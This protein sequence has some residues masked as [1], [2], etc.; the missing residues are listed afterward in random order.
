MTTFALAVTLAASAI[1]CNSARAADNVVAPPIL[2]N[3]N[4]AWSWFEDERAVVD[5]TGGKLLVS[6]VGDSAGSGGTARNG[7][8]D[9]VSYNL[10]TGVTQSFLLHDNLQDDDHNSAA[11]FVRPDGKYLAM[12]ARHGSDNFSRWRISTNPHDATAW[13]PEQTFN[14][15]AGTTYSNLHYLPADN[16]GAGRTYNFTRTNNYDP[17]VLVSD[18]QGAS[19]SYGGKLLTEGGGGDRPYVRYFDDG[20]RI[21]LITTER[22]PR[23]Y[24]NSVYYG[25][26][27][28]AKLYGAG[29]AVLDANLLDGAAVTPASLTPVMQTGTVVDGD[30]MR[31][32]WTVDAAVDGAGD[33]VVVFQARAN[34]SDLDHRFF[35][36]RWTG[37]SWQVN[38][39]AFAGSYLYGA[40]NDYTGL[41]AID[42]DDTST[43]YLSSE[44][45]P[46]TKAQL[47]GADGQRHYELFKGVTDDGGATWAWSPITFNSTQH[48]VRPIVPKW[49]A[50]NTA[51]LWLRGDYSTYTSFDTDVV[52][53]VNADIPTPKLAMAIDFGATGQAV[54]ADFAA[55]TR[56]TNPGGG[57]QTEMFDS[58]YAAAGQQVSVTL[59]GGVQFADRGN[60]VAGPLGDV[61]DDFAMAGDNLTIRFGNLARGNYQLV[62]YAH[63]RD[64][65]Q[66]TYD[67][68][69]NGVDLGTLNPVSGANPAI[70]IAS[71]RIEFGTSGAGDV[72]LTLAD[73]GAGGS[74]VL[75]GLE[76]Y[77]AG[78]YN[79]P[80][81]LN[82][83]GELDVLD[84]QKYVL[85]WHVDLSGLTTQ[86]A[87]EMGDLNGDLRNDFTDF[88]LFK[89]AYDQWNGAGAFAKLTAAVPEPTSWMLLGVAGT[90]VAATKFRHPQRRV[91]A[92]LIGVLACLFAV[93]A[94]RSA[95]AAL[96]YV[97]AN[98]TTN[99][100][101]AAAFTPG[102]NDNADDNLWS[103]RTGF[104]SGG[105]IIQSGDGNGENAPE[106]STTLT[107]LAPN[108][109]Y[110]VYLHF[111]DGS[112][113]DPDWN[114][115]GGFSSGELTLFANPADAGDIG[116][117]DAVLASSLD[118][119][120]PPT[121]FAEADRTMYAGRLGLAVANDAG[122]LTVY[123][124]DLPS[125]IG[126]NNRT[127]YDGVSYESAAA[128]TLLV[129][130][131][132]GF[133]T[134]INSTP[135]ALPLD[136]YE[137]RS[138][139]SP[140]GSLN[141]LGWAS[142]DSTEGNDPVG[143]GWDEAPGSDSTLLSEGN[144]TSTLTLAPNDTAPLGN[145]FTLG[146]AQDLEFFYSS[147]GGQLAQGVVVYVAGLAGDFDNDGQVDGADF[148]RWQRGALSNP[149]SPATLADWEANFGAG[150]SAVLATTATPE[151]RSLGSALLAVSVVVAMRLRS[152]TM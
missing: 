72:T 12:Y 148:L 142:F 133:V 127:W 33:P 90:T 129:N 108:S 53:L 140:V 17:N 24:D 14:N 100:G 85:G 42:P 150:V 104:A 131:T 117:E 22:H 29:G 136:Y 62:L 98:R 89:D 13:E 143:A 19:W 76:L 28:D 49:D 139:G 97:D 121:V 75:N 81:D 107:G 8:I 122:E 73:G 47:I 6:S 30:A 93:A 44:V 141:K 4:G 102:V 151:P 124:D 103:E 95:R 94:G 91:G 92:A 105:N 7:D 125:Q 27:E 86:Q 60:D 101:P 114:I 43:V 52:G 83:D 69:L 146:S 40:E 58:P 66:S 149:P 38:Q 23:N 57:D 50:E 18:D 116:A 118:Y 120:T 88:R 130:T 135:A 54:Q 61:A 64:A 126:V 110:T 152:A 82:S 35:Y 41:V 67:I 147:P 119:V 87:Y 144:L 68:L 3:D 16:G 106:I 59:G 65:E 20:N 36:G 70:G 112:G 96:T 37:S 63:D 115:R 51:V 1:V 145:A 78:P 55:F 5:A 48:N 109:A 2:L 56:G 31:R 84:F 71:A 25:Y 132:N 134:V 46:A 111:W 74:V 137:I 9:V 26:I 99:T 15:G 32:M 123:V 79:P 39:L 77:A 10:A 128:P 80:Y 34:D 11:L 138:A 113:A 45:H 21:H